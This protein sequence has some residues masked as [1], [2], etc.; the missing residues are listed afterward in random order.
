MTLALLLNIFPIGLA[1]QAV[2]G[3]PYHIL[4]ACDPSAEV[5]ANIESS[6]PLEIRYSIGG[7]STCYAVT[8]MVDGKPVR[9][10]VLDRGLDAI[11]AFEKERAAHPQEFTSAP[12][13]SAP[14]PPPVTQNKQSNSSSKDPANNAPRKKEPQPT[15]ALKKTPNIDL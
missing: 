3:S 14:P 7:S 13:A 4:S 5:L 9:G 2:A 12:A 11:Q 6:A 8:A 10:Y 15:D 1:L